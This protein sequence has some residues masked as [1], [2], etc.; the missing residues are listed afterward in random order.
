VFHSLI[1]IP[2]STEVSSVSQASARRR[3]PEA[4]GC[5]V[6]VAASRHRHCS[7]SSSEGVV[8]C[9]VVDAR[10]VVRLVA[11][12]ALACRCV[13]RRVFC[14]QRASRSRTC[15]S[16]G[17][18]WH[19]AGGFRPSIRWPSCQGEGP[20]IVLGSHRGVG[21]FDA[22]GAVLILCDHLPSSQ[23]LW[24]VSPCLCSAPACS[25]LF[26]SGGELGEHAVAVCCL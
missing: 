9:A 13:V 15:T 16:S 23:R 1:A 8:V 19:S 10:R 4:S 2:G 17:V 20:A 25:V 22:R 21:L 18:A 7:V 11:F 14:W 3:A 6:G 12:V 24:V 26:C 5:V